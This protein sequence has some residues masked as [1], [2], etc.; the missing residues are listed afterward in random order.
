MKTLFSLFLLFNITLLIASE[1]KLEHVTL[2]LQWKH[3][4]EFAGFYAAKEKGFYKEVGLDVDF[5]EHD[6][7]KSISDK[8]LDGDVEYGLSYSSIIVDY[9]NNKPFVFLANFFKQSP[10][11][12]IAQ[13]DIKTPAD[14]EGKKIMG[15]ADSVHSMTILNM[16]NKFSVNRND[17]ES[18]KTDYTLEPF[19][20]KKVDAM[21]VFITN[22]PYTLNKK[23]IKYKLFDP[24]VYGI[25]YYDLNLFTT[26]EEL[27]NHPKRVK[28]FTEASI[29]GWK[30]ALS[31]KQEIVELIQKKYNTQNKTQDSLMFEAE[32]IESIMLPSVYPVGS[33]DRHRVQIIVDDFKQAGVIDRED[34]KSIEGFIYSNSM[35][36]I[37][38]T[39]REKE[40]LDSVKKLKICVSPDW[41][42]FGGIEDDKYIGI[43]SDYVTLVSQKIKTQIEVY[44]TQSRK[45]SI[46]SLKSGK[47]NILS[48]VV[49]TKKREKLFNLTS[50]YLKYKIV[51]VT[52][53]DK[54]MIPDI[55]YLTNEKI[56]VVEDSAEIDLIEA[57]YPN[58]EVV[59][60]KSIKDG[61]DKVE[62]DEVYGLV[63]N[64]F[65]I[66]HYF[67]NSSYSEFK[68]VT[69]L[70]EKLS[71]SYAVQKEDT[72][73]Y[74]IMQKVVDS[75]THE[76]KEKI[77][78]KWFSVTYKKV[79]DYE[80]LW[81]ILLVVA[82]IFLFFIVRHFNIKKVNKELKVLIEEEVRKSREK[83]QL[84]FHQS[85][86]VSMGEMIENI[87]HQW[88]QPLSQINSAVL[89]LDEIMVENA[90]VIERAEEKLLEIETLTGYMSNT[91][92]DFKNFYSSDKVK[93]NFLLEDIVNDAIKVVKGTL[94]YYSISVVIDKE[95]DLRCNGYS[96][97]LQ[98]VLVII[99]NNAKD[100]LV[101]NEVET[102]TIEIRLFK[103]EGALMIEIYDNGGGLQPEL[104]TKIFEPYFTTKHK[105][106]GTGLGLY[107]AKVVIEES[108]TGQLSVKNTNDGACFKIKILD[109]YE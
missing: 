40:Y 70:D 73:L 82:L 18:V 51:V 42:P 106:Q 72:E 104:L 49:P 91:I 26:Q 64:A 59:K 15:I 68:V 89:V 98:Q 97:E 10:L 13:D 22:E 21:S 83:D 75:L 60:V 63:D 93:K 37:L 94:S 85:K 84:I 56:A 5:L 34:E 61:L 52:K 25:K 7:V 55:S 9:Y 17:Y 50:S 20:D 67:Q 54:K 96:N 27:E 29:K 87:A 107:I 28:N 109:N 30:Y 2:Q 14:L 69:Q 24:M 36:N 88:R 33:I 78:N 105:S 86:L 95:D 74:G 32:Q 99:L 45:E 102:P 100:I 101:Q 48:L 31:H 46:E 43:D 62:S 65:V 80:L 108:L 44:K 39:Q 71:L 6:S 35:N 8:V 23:G 16:L 57:K 53:T 58:I 38:L 41:M 19:I 12:L 90:F 66:D 1:N 4:F 3:Q 79:Y 103:E 11:V 77:L 81:K 47:C 92:N 76:H